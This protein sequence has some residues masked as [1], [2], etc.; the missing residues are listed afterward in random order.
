MLEASAFLLT[1]LASQS[2]KHLHWALEPLEFLFVTG[3]VIQC[4]CYVPDLR[5]VLGRPDK[6][7]SRPSLRAGFMEERT[8]CPVLKHE[9]ESAR[10]RAGS[11]RESLPDS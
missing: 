7:H 4:T 1:H 6:G 8:L 3:S 11:G 5:Q 9:V 2:W 10:D